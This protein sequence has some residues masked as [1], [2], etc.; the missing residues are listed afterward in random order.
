MDFNEVEKQIFIAIR[1]ISKRKAPDRKS[2]DEKK[3]RIF[4]KELKEWGGSLDDLIKRGLIC[5][6]EEFLT[7]AESIKE[8]VR[9]MA[10]EWDSEGF[11]DWLIKSEQSRA[12]SK[13]CECLYGK[14]LCQ[15]SMM[16]MKQLDRLLQLLALNS[17][18]RVLDLGCGVGAITEYIGDSTG[19]A[20]TGIDFASGAIKRAQDRTRAKAERLAFQVQNLDN[21]GFP[22]G[23][24]DAI[25][26]VDALGFVADLEDLFARCKKIL[27]PGGQMGLFHSQIIA[28]EDSR[29]L[30]RADG[31]KPA[32]ALRRNNLSFHAW[33]YTRDECDHWRRSKEIA[34][35]LKT[36]FEAEGYLELYESHLKESDRLLQVV[37]EG[38]IS[39]FLYH[40]KA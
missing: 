14:D 25:I 21:I 15:C 38:R 32:Q 27:I 24:F 19:A 7:I 11:S 26:C 9:I 10:D 18:S 8:K 12:Y 37:N 3:G 29:D 35:E 2:L 39:R 36:E 31:T 17:S 20:M 6:Q 40:V 13:F 23:S 34:E 30:L 16:S 1:L 5:E 28:V 4:G 22:P 33:D